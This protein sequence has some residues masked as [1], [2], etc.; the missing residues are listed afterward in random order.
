[1]HR[2]GMPHDRVLAWL[3]DVGLRRAIT[4]EG[5]FT[6]L[7]EDQD[8]DREQA[9]RLNALSDAAR[10]KDLSLG[11]LHAA[12]SDALAQRTSET[13]L[14]AVRTGLT[15]YGGYPT[16]DMM[17]RG[18]LRP[19]YRLKAR[20][21]R[22]DELAAGEGSS[23]HRRFRAT[24]PIGTATLA[25]GH[26]DGYPTGAV[27]G[28]VIS[29]RGRLRPVIGTVSASHTVV[30]LGDDAAVRVGDEAI[31]VGSDDPAIHPNEVAKRSDWSEYNMF[32]HLNPALRRVVVA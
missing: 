16:P 8:F 23:Y 22:V 10:G 13:F 7:T 28:C 30:S 18:E 31:A 1:M 5:A 15:I 29:I 11:R 27:K 19:V 25:L 24:E 4:V 9:R 20:V 2:M 32:M 6:E 14:D 3:N 26:V 21:I 12:S 17:A